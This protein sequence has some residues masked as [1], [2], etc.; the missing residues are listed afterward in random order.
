MQCTSA[1]PTPMKEI[2]LNAM[3]AM[4]KKFKVDIGI[5][6]HSMGIEVPIAAVA[7]GAKIVEKH[8]TLDKNLAGSDQEASIEPQELKLMI[9]SIRN[10]EK[11]L[12]DGV[13]K[14]EKSEKSNKS[15]ARKSIV[16]SHKIK[17]GE[18]FTYNNISIKRPGTGISPMQFD[19]IL[20]TKSDYS[21]EKDDLIKLK[22]Q[23]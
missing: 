19:K 16:A 22:K 2:N 8:F 15:V 18:I 12:G 21:F 1:Y 17:K 14:I 11:A 10:I 9:E 4:K 3:L 6:D 20:D 7:I 23:R 5:S 13:K